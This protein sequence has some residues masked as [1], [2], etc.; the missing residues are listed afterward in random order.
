M[1]S[2]A[3]LLRGGRLRPLRDS[4]SMRTHSFPL[5][6]DALLK[7]RDDQI[8]E[9][10]RER[11]RDSR[12]IKALSVERMRLQYELRAATE[13][14]RRLKGYHNLRGALRYVAS[15][16]GGAHGDDVQARLDSLLTDDKFAELLS[17]EA[18][19]AKVFESNARDCLKTIYGS[20]LPGRDAATATGAHEVVLDGD[21]LTKEQRVVLQ[22]ILDYKGVQY[23]AIDVPF[24][25]S[26]CDSDDVYDEWD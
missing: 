22:T 11:A 15:T 10:M 26:T 1:L 17:D 8:C 16:L 18:R 25:D 6:V 7:R 13:T 19:R 20:R 9:L 5:D 23:R 3:V 4:Y 21:A 2:Q 12:E 14:I 24:D